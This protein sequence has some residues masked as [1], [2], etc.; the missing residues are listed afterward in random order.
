MLHSMAYAIDVVNQEGFPN[1]L[2]IKGWVV[3]GGDYTIAMRGDRFV[4]A[5]RTKVRSLDEVSQ[6]LGDWPTG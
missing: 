1:W 3:N 4:I 2:P 6:L 5:N